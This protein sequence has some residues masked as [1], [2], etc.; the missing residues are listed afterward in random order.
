MDS[1]QLC[2]LLRFEHQQT[3]V[4]QPMAARYCKVYTPEPVRFAYLKTG[5]VGLV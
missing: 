4:F 5:F 2:R 1:L 3:D